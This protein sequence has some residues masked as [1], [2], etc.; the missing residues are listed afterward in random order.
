MEVGTVVSSILTMAAMILIGSLLARTV[1]FTPERRQL[2]ITIIIN[3][4]MP[5][6][7]L[8]GVFHTEIDANFLALVLLIFLSSIVINCL[9]VLLGWL[10]ARGMRMAPDK[11]KEMALLSGLGNTGFIGIP[12]CAALFGPKGALL[13]AIFDAG[14]DVTIWT[15]GVLMLQGGSGF[16]LRSLRSLMNIPM[17]AIIVG[18]L[19]AVLHVTPPAGVANLTEILANLASPL[20]MLYLGMLI[21][22][23][24]KK[25]RTTTWHHLSMPLIMKLL[26]FPVATAALLHLL[27]LPLEVAQVIIVQSTMPTL[28]LASI[29]FAK[30]S[31]DEEYGATMTVFSTLVS[32]TTI[33][34]MTMVG[35]YLLVK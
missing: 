2:L 4:A 22:S 27:S 16:T 5:C 31:R 35:F 29:L 20:A 24:L 8:N 33:P 12:L 3:V 32:M 10:A 30:Y 13:A 7:V 9:G 17:A 26:I 19:A 18:M 15:L 11:A 34:V 14:L 6:I 25:K 21:P 1:P 23:M 28:T